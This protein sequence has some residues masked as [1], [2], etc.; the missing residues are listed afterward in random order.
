[1]S[2]VHSPGPWSWDEEGYDLTASNGRKV[3]SQ[4]V[5]SDTREAD[6]HL[7]AAAPDMLD[8]LCRIKAATGSITDDCWA[9]MM[10]AIS[11]AQSGGR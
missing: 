11:R 4:S 8:V 2:A 1:M 9:Q 10:A 7:L 6:R 3:I 5:D